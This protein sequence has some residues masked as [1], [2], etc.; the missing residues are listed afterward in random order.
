MVVWSAPSVA[1]IFFSELTMGGDANVLV[2]DSGLTPE[3]YLERGEVK[4]PARE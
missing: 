1:E 4:A 3:V 2:K